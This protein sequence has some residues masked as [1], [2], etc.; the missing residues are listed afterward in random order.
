MSTI[1]NHNPTPTSNKINRIQKENEN[2]GIF[3]S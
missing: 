3:Q 2:K 1:D